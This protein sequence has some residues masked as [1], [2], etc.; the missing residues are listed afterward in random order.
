MKG[1]PGALL[2]LL[3]LLLWALPGEV[4]SQGG[5]GLPGPPERLMA[6]ALLGLPDERLLPP[7]P[8]RG[9]FPE[10]AVE[11]RTVRTGRAVLYSALLPGLGQRSLGKG[12]WTAFV[13]A[14]LW[15]VLQYVD[16]RSEGRRLED[17]YR[18]LAWLVARRVSSGPRVEGDFE[19]YEAMTRYSASGAWDADPQSPG[20]QP[21]E[22]PETYNGTIW[23]LA[24]EIYLPEDG[25]NAEEPG[26]PQF[27]A[28]IA[29]YLSRAYT[30]DLTWSWG[31]NDL[32]QAEFARLIEASDENLRQATTMIGI[33]LANHLLSAV[34]ALVIGR[35][36][37]QGEEEPH[38]RVRLL[39]VP[40][41]PPAL[42]VT[43]R[44]S[45]F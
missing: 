21:E 14:E 16:Q 35:L 10:Q 11:P 4:S 32:Q 22:D 29:Y 34:D 40:F 7:P 33:I 42:G 23:T 24:R 15:A 43:L 6:S 39:P 38:L 37:A 9:G 3:A 45:L 41:Q 5:V 8:S 13:A 26:S 18:D 12:R 44:F 2:P 27:E 31:N 19:Y 36:Q 1:P 28:A 30:P 17:R 20:V 25:G